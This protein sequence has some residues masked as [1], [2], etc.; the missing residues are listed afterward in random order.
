MLA[1][2]PF[3][4]GL[5][6]NIPEGSDRTSDGPPPLL[7]QGCRSSLIGSSFLFLLCFPRR[8]RRDTTF[9]LL[10]AKEFSN[11]LFS[12]CGD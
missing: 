6:K 12:I 2:G 10:I 1:I 9:I 11:L 5:L 3:K 7:N 4:V 8:E